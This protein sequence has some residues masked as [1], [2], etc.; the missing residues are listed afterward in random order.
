MRKSYKI[1]LGLIL[2]ANFIGCDTRSYE[3]ISGTSVIPVTVKYSTDVKPVVSANC[4]SCH[5]ANG[6]ASYFPLTDYNLV[7]DAIENIL[8][9]VQKPAGDPD[10]MPQ[11]GSLSQQNIDILKKW[12]TDGLQ[13]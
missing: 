8:V 7:K 12:K 10:K 3:E 1:L 13:E 9:R 2:I 4:I 11:G 6:A 5:S